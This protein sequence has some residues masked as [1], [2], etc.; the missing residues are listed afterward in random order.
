MQSQAGK[1]ASAVHL[2]VTLLCVL[3]SSACSSTT[4]IRVGAQGAA[5]T[6]AGSGRL[7]NRSQAVR[8]SGSIGPEDAPSG[9]EPGICASARCESFRLTIDLPNPTFDRAR[10]GGVEISLRWF[11]E[12]DALNLYVY[13]DGELVASGEGIIATAHSLFL[14]AAENGEYQ[15]LVAYDA[16]NSTND[17]V[18][19][20]ALA[21][22]EF[23]PRAQPVRQ[24]LPDLVYRPQR[25]VTFDL[26]LA[27]FEP[28]PPPGSS[29]YTSETDEDGAQN[30]LRFDQV[31]ANVGVGDL[32]TRLFVPKDANDTEH[33]SYQRIYYSDSRDHY[34]D[35]LSSDWVFHPIHDHYHVQDF[36]QTNLWEIDAQGRRAGSEPLRVGHK[37]SFCIADI[38]LDEWGSKGNGPRQYNAPDCLSVAYSDDTFNYYVTG[39][40]RG[41][42]DIYE[43]YLPGQYVEVS[44][45]PDG[46]YILET[47]M[48]PDNHLIESDDS[49]NCGSLIVEISGVGTAQARAQIV[50]PGPD[51]STEPPCDGGDDAHHDP[52]ADQAH[53]H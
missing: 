33:H 11:D 8:W 52:Q 14:P 34:D 20:E 40:S 23:L 29:C 28:A 30:C 17:A 43:Y 39:L 1:L 37:I 49:N 13:R 32:E 38:E 51:C 25:N 27:F 53:E 4:D 41:W 31:M 15:V 2:T 36:A 12:F 18:P 42:A 5:L 44:G 26:D 48:D 3:L 7:R 47:V 19:Y 16:A 6:D 10:D 9:G 46:N 24:L 22:V 35:V 50:G 45:V 21:E